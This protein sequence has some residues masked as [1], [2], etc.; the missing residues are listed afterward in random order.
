VVSVPVSRSF[1]AFVSP[2]SPTVSFFYCF[3]LYLKKR[4]TRA[5]LEVSVG[6]AT[7][8]MEK[9]YPSPVPATVPD[10]MLACLDA[11]G[12]PVLKVSDQLLDKA[13][14]LQREF[15]LLYEETHTIDGG[16]G[17]DV[18][19]QPGGPYTVAVDVVSGAESRASISIIFNMYL[20]GGRAVADM[21]S[22]QATVYP[23]AGARIA[24]SE[25]TR[26]CLARFE[27]SGFSGDVSVK[28]YR[29][30]GGGRPVEALGRLTLYFEDY[31]QKS[32]LVGLGEKYYRVGMPL[33]PSGGVYMF[34]VH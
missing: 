26:R 34:G 28:L 2:Y 24:F 14:S 10:Y 15:E 16:G 3:L 33:G 8:S 9:S 11:R 17:F 23:G 1:L 21:L 25:L 13:W 4:I 5:R 19:L 22:Y 20:D 18:D 31:S 32:F 7:V 6:Q 29:F 30:R 12:D 27:I